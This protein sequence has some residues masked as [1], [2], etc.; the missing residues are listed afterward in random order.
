MLKIYRTLGLAA[1]L[2]FPQLT[3]A[4]S[5][6]PQAL[7]QIESRLDFCARVDYGSADKYKELGKAIVA[8][9]SEKELKEAR[10][11]NEYKT[12][13]DAMTGRL[14]KIPQEKAVEGCRAGLKEATK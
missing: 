3:L 13:Y 2:T 7:G 9:M 11:S 4:D 10:E 5:V 6:P 8:G 1:I 12:E 14:E